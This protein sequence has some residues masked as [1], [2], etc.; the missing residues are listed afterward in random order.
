[1]MLKHGDCLPH[2][3]GSMLVSR[4]LISSPFFED[5]FFDDCS[6]ACGKDR[7]PFTVKRRLECPARPMIA[8]KI[9]VCFLGLNFLSSGVPKVNAAGERMDALE[10]E[11][12]TLNPEDP[13]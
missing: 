1:M 9:L 2:C 6:R 8:G 12:T 11:M 3:V 13:Q 5:C 7:R 4:T 10:H